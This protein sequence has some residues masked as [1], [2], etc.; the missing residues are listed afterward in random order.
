MVQLLL[1]LAADPAALIVLGDR[2]ASAAPARVG[3]THTGGG[4]IAVEQPA[5]DTL[6]ITMAGVAVA[7]P[8][9]CKDSSAALLFDLAQDIEVKLPDGKKKARLT[10]EARLVG[11]LRSHKHGSAGIHCPASASIHAGAVPLI[12]VGLRGRAVAA[13]ENLSVNDRQG[14]A[15]VVVGAGT[16]ALRQKFGVQASHPKGLFG[17][18]ASAEFA[19]DPALDPLW[20]SAWEPFRG[21][22]KKEFGFQA[23]LK[24]AAE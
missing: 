18:T 12:E 19:P 9:P 3:F 4:N 6:V 1:L 21:A 22:G 17:K 23:T 16:Y 20:I 24:V 14:P 2:Q 8:H 5:P 15:G 13:G 10:L 7:G 11:L